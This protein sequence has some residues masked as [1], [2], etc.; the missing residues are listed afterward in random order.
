MCDLQFKV[1]SKER[2]YEAFLDNLD[3]QICTLHDN[4]WNNQNEIHSTALYY[5]QKHLSKWP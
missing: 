3:N 1:I 4:F 2:C 5:E